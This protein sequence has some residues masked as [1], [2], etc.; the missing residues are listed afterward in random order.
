MANWK[1]GPALPSTKAKIAQVDELTRGG[2]G[3]IEA[4]AHV[5]LDVPTWYRHGPRPTVD[6]LDG[7]VDVLAALAG[8]AA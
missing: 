1:G 2:W 6:P 8:K 5:G 3:L 4:C 7:L